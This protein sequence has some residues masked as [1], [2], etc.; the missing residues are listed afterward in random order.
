MYYVDEYHKHVVEIKKPGTNSLF[1]VAPNWKQ[2]WR[3]KA[4]QYSRGANGTRISLQS[5]RNAVKLGCGD[6][7]TTL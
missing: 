2:R 6:G 4:Y 3:Q 1:T 7:C 5:D